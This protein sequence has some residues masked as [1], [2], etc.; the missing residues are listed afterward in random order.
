[1]HAY[2]VSQAYTH[3]CAS[4]T[5]TFVVSFGQLGTFPSGC[6][7]FQITVSMLTPFPVLTVCLMCLS[8]WVCVH[9]YVCVCVRVFACVYTIAQLM[10][11][12]S[13]ISVGA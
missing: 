2:N 5:Q 12:C 9:V 1:M 6:F 11:E 7:K 4:C 3:D 8:A 10:E 13:S